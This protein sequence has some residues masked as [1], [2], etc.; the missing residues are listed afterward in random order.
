VR[1]G[2]TGANGALMIRQGR[3]RSLYLP[4]DLIPQPGPSAHRTGIVSHPRL[5]SPARPHT[6][7]R[8]DAGADME[9][10]HAGD[11]SHVRTCACVR[12]GR[13]WIGVTAHSAQY[14]AP[15]SGVRVAAHRLMTPPGGH[16]GVCIQRGRV[17]YTL[18]NAT[19]CINN[20]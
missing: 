17:L 8:L 4:R 15:S 2:T 7:S 18:C 11:T 9:A 16:R 1:H 6:S 12:G 13:Q 5:P 19:L 3:T 14:A 20:Y 10:L